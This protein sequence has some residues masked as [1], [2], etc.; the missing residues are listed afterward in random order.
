VIPARITRPGIRTR[1]VAVMV[2]GS[3][4]FGVIVLVFLRVLVTNALQKT[5]QETYSHLLEAIASDISDHVLTGRNFDLQILLFEVTRRDPHLQYLIAI[6]S[7]GE[8]IASSYGGQVPAQL[9]LLLAEAEAGTNG[10]NGDP[11]LLSDRGHDLVHLRVGIL[12][13]QLGILH[14]GIEQES[15]QASAARITLNLVVI[16]VA[17]TVAGVVAAFWMGRLLTEPLRRMSVLA[18]RI[19]AGDL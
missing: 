19:G 17:L 14:A 8:I 4:A 2:L 9:Q 1:F 5:T 6:D 15:M 7:E 16:F 12:G 3:L 11:L 13:G 10:A 18:R